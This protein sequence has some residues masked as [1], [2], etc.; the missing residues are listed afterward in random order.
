[1]LDYC[2]HVTRER[3]SH[4]F[5][6]QHDQQLASSCRPS[7]RLSVRQSVTLCILALRIGVQGYKLYQRVPSRQVPMGTLKMREMK[8]WV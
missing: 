8:M 5:L 3:S 4:Q 6:A 7:V 1:M 2:S